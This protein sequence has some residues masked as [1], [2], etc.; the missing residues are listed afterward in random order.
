MHRKNGG[1]EAKG[2]KVILYNTSLNAMLENGAAY[3]EKLKDVFTFFKGSK[4]AVL[5]WRP[6]PL[7]E[8]SI[9]SMRPELYE[10]YITLKKWFL[11]EKIGIYD[12]TPDMYTA[13]RVQRCLLRRSEFGR[14][15]LQAD[16]KTGTDTKSRSFRG[17]IMDKQNEKIYVTQSSMPTYEEYIEAIK[18]LWDSHWLTNMGKYHKELEKELREY[19]DVPQISL[20]V[21]GHMALEMAIQAMDFPEGAE[22]ITTPFTFISTT[23]AM[24]CETV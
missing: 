10:A 7:M 21:N 14:V 18:P 11:E 22:V 1:K 2:K 3:I 6:H 8:S 23:H 16:R 20:M 9:A 19:L 4:E 12:D 17:K 24:A 13:D 5:L 15:A